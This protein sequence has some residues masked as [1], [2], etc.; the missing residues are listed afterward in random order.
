MFLYFFL[1]IFVKKKL[2]FLKIDTIRKITN[3]ARF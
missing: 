3:I 1:Y 2:T